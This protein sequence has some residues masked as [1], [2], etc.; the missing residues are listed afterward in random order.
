VI[1]VTHPTPGILRSFRG[2][3]D[4]GTLSAPNLAVVG[5]RHAAEI[6]R[7]RY[8]KSQIV[9]RKYPWIYLK[10]IDCSLEPGTLF[11]DNAC[12]PTF[13]ALFRHSSAIVFTGGA[14]LPPAVYGQKTRL[15]TSIRT[16]RRHYW[17]LS[18][19]FH[20]L[21]S[22]R[23]P[24]H[25]P[26]LDERPDYPVL[27]I[28]LGMQAM[29]VAAGGTLHQDILTDIYRVTTYEDAEKLPPEQLHRNVDYFLHPA[30]GKRSGLFHPVRFKESK[31]P[32]LAAMGISHDRLVKVIS[33]HHQAVDRLGKDLE[34][35]ATSTD[36]KVVEGL[37]H[38]R[39]PNVLGVQFHPEYYFLGPEKS[40]AARI[41]D[42]GAQTFHLRFWQ[43]F[44]KRLKPVRK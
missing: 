36:G 23:A 22:A 38:R 15:T 9:A 43:A 16:P 18:F 8:A 37:R 11:K 7:D 31:D 35:I 32:L 1:L 42:E 34:V 14:D 29:N 6:E 28:C 41:M 26:L 21:G 44:G 13:K 10:T 12:T 40:Y 20:L 17:E 39:F 3:V 27:G 4:T 2:I 30:R 33:I 24:E 25:K 5:V 19:L